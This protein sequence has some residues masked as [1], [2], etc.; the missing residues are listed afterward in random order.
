VGFNMTPLIDVVLL[1]I[2]F[3]LLSSHLARQETEQ[4][5]PLPAAQ[6][7]QREWAGDR[8][9]LTINVLAS[10]DVLVANRTIDA[11]RLAALLANRRRAHGDALEV[12]LRAD[13]SIPYA[14]VEAILL[15][16]TGA[17]IRS[18]TFAVTPKTETED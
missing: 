16:C 4:A 9:R 1:L 5:L 2:I 12:R 13:R 18:V 6:S 14:R 10:G 15:A 8:P 17:G 3:F 7:G 11:D